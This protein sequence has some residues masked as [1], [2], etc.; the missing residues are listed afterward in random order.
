MLLVG[1]DCPVDA[2]NVH[3][4]SNNGTCGTMLINAHKLQDDL[5]VFTEPTMSLVTSWFIGKVYELKFTQPQFGVYGTK[6]FSTGQ[7][8]DMVVLQKGGCVGV[9]AITLDK[10]HV[11]SSHSTKMTLKDYG[12]GVQGEEK[13][14]A[15]KMHTIALGKVNELLPGIYSIC[16]ATAQSDG[17]DDT[18]FKMLD[19]P[20]EILPKSATSVRLTVPRTVQ[21]GHDLVVHWESDNNLHHAIQSQ[22]SWIGLYKNDSCPEGKT[23]TQYWAESCT[24]RTQIDNTQL[25]P[26]ISE[27]LEEYIEV[28]PHEC[29]VAYQFI[30]GGV[31]SGTVR[32]SQKDYKY[33]GSFDVRFFEGDTRNSQ[34]RICKGMVNV[35]H[36]SY[37][38]CNLE[39]TLVSSAIEV[40]AHTDM[41]DDLNVIPGME[42][43]FDNDKGHFKNAHVDIT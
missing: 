7:P 28:D 17:D 27:T 31:G 41:L 23:G 1:S 2:P 15:A 3:T 5:Q 18:D 42:V 20:F 6:T 30:K 37:V 35:N 13:G 26:P 12:E 4:N 14:A 25:E 40:Y 19:T 29:W 43:F 24:L 33:A 21:L 11:G 36:E 34:G 39:T 8:G 22:N 10:Y 32:F 9:S 38:Q 16:Y